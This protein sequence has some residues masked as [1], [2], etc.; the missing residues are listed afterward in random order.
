MQDA[1][2]AGFHGISNGSAGHGSHVVSWEAFPIDDLSYTPPEGWA[3]E[4]PSIFSGVTDTY[5][6]DGKELGIAAASAI[7]ANAAWGWLSGQAYGKLAELNRSA[8]RALALRA[9]EV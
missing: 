4:E 6:E 1:V 9:A 8:V 2:V 5:V 7:G 3:K